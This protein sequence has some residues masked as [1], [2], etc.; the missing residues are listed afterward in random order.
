MEY[1][2]NDELEITKSGGH[3]RGRYAIIVLAIVTAL[4]IT[5]RAVL[6]VVAL[7]TAPTL[8]KSLYDHL[9]GPLL[10]TMTIR[11]IG[12]CFTSPNAGRSI[13]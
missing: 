1:F 4:S 9:D 12:V 5:L 8:S 11:A 7:L 13:H 10:R 6:I 2:R 3:A